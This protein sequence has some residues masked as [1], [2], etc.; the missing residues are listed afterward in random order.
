MELA[1][2]NGFTEMSV[3]ENQGVSGG[4]IILIAIGSATITITGTQVLGAIGTAYAAGKVVGE[5]KKAFFTDN[6]PY[7]A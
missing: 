7:Y 3:E 6:G 4:L 5:I 1:L 2:N